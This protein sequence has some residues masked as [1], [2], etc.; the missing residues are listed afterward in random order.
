MQATA[1]EEE[2]GIVHVGVCLCLCCSVSAAALGSSWPCRLSGIRL[3]FCLD[4]LEI[5]FF[6]RGIAYTN[7]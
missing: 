3:D 4:S 2:D 6:H 1:T 7:T 5:L